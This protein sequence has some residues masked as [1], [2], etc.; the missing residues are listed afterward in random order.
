MS[1]WRVWDPQTSDDDPEFPREG[2]YAFVL[3][4]SYANGP[5]VLVAQWDKVDGWIVDGSSDDLKVTHWHPLHFPPPP[6]A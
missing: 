6:E 5:L 1:E 4:G 2:G 3:E